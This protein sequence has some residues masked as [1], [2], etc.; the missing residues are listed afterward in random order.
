MFREEERELS[1]KLEWIRKQVTE[2]NNAFIN[3]RSPGGEKESMCRGGV[4]CDKQTMNYISI[5]V[6][7][8][9]NRNSGRAGCAGVARDHNGDWK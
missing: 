3:A 5:N 8:G 1:W 4:H 6:D 7:G 9:V 2:I